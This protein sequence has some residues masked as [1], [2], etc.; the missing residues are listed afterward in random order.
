MKNFDSVETTETIDN[1]K[2]K[3]NDINTQI[4]IIDIEIAKL[5]TK[6]EPEKLN[7]LK[8]KLKKANDK[9][10]SKKQ[11][12][13]NIKNNNLELDAKRDKVLSKIKEL[14]E[15]EIQ[16]LKD[17]IKE[18]EIEITKIKTDRNTIIS[19]RLNTIGSELQKI[20]LDKSNLSNKMKL[21]Q[22]DGMNLKT[23]NDELDKEIEELKNSTICP[24]CGREYDKDDTEHMTSHI[25][26]KIQKLIKE[27]EVNE[28]K[29]RVLMFEYKRI[30]SQLPEFE[31]K[32]SD[33][34]TKKKLLN[35]CVY[36]E[37]VLKQLNAVGNIE[38]IEK[39]IQNIRFKIEEVKS[40]VFINT[41]KLKEYV[42][43][44]ETLLRNIEKTKSDNFEVI[45]NLES[46]LKS[47]NIDSIEDV[48]SH[49]EKVKENYELRN[50]KISTKENLILS[51]AN[52]ELMIKES[53]SI[54]DKYE[55][56]KQQIDENEILQNNLNRIDEHILILKN[57]IKETNDDILQLEKDITI[58][59][60][61]IESITIKLNKF[62]KQKK[63]EELLKE[64]QRCVSRD[65]L[66]T[67][68]L[69]KSIHLIN[70]ELNELLA[71]VDFTL[72]FDEN[73]ILRMSADDRLDVSQNVL[74]SSG[75]ERTFCSLALKIALRQVNI[76]SKPSMILLDECMGKL[77]GESVQQFIDFLDLLKTK[78][79]KIIIIEHIHPIDYQSLI[80]VKKDEYTLVSSLEIKI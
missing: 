15:K 38:V 72:F 42:T 26:D 37:E 11:E 20:E 9:V 35:T 5:P 14:K 77:I 54:L 34:I 10:T 56:Y 79:K 40:D 48:I 47:F 69:K 28:E 73:L 13:Q 18:S 2:N 68:L 59:N 62:L 78:I 25:E 63:K 41:E 3:I 65:G 60:K 16:K 19:D 32:V 80:E 52:S 67:Y 22:K 17:S 50:Q 39:T 7:T 58:K 76:R 27:K 70:K 33:L 45:K 55:E 46:E 24:T 36:E 8:T 49:E 74:E 6:F 75:K 4:S 64:Y 29:I 31:R 43:Q 1:Y 71:N 61:D 12:I 44:G 53:Q 57:S 23:K 21:L 30:K 51:I 66:P